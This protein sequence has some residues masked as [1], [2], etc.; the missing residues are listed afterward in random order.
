MNQ[1]PVCSTPI[2]NSFGLVEC[3]GCNKILFS[4][5]NGNLAIHSEEALDSSAA[6]QSDEI[7]VQEAA[8][9]DASWNFQEPSSEESIEAE[10]FGIEDPVV[11]PEISS[12]AISEINEFA[13]SEAS[14]LKNGQWLYT[15]TINAID[16]EDLKEEVI[17]SL[18]DPKLGIPHDLLDFALPTLSLKDIN[19]VKASVIVSRIKHLPVKLSWTQRSVVM[20]GSEVAD[21]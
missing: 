9:E 8:T 3:P 17:E 4:D 15:L 18:R 11:E 16:T 2:E 20:D 7:S 21:D 5:F 19:A 1:C 10:P 6:Q 12:G 13:N 14:S